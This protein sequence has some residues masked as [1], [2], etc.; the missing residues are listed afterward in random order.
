MTLVV[1][2]QRR[3]RRGTPGVTG[4]RSAS[5]SAIASVRRDGSAAG[6]GG[7][8]R[9]LGRGRRVGR[10]AGSGVGGCEGRLGG[11]DGIGIRG[12]RG[13]RNGLS[14]LSH[15]RSA[16]A[17]G[18]AAASGVGETSSLV[19]SWTSEDALR[20][21]RR[22]FPIDAPTSGSLPGPRMSSA[23]T[24][25]MIELGSPDVRHVSWCSSGGMSLS[26]SASRT[27]SGRRK[28]PT[29]V[30]QGGFATIRGRPGEAFPDIRRGPFGRRPRGTGDP[31]R[32]V[33]Q[34]APARVVRRPGARRR[35]RWPG[36]ARASPP[37]APTP[38][39]RN[40]QA[41]RDRTDRRELD[42][43]GGAH[44]QPDRAA[45]APAPARRAT[46]GYSGSAG[47]PASGAGATS[48]SCS[49]PA[50]GFDVRHST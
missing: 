32:D 10:G 31:P 13:R 8:A 24:R 25:M 18:A 4:S 33:H 11:R 38:G 42:R 29:R 6:G 44:D 20:N 45:R 9:R 28:P 39:T 50:P 30:A 15:G 19:A 49:S 43:G 47:A 35:T 14:G 37:C 5:A 34:Q 46:R 7:L 23:I 17:T 16:G 48:R 36:P 40:A 3:G 1:V 22:L 27:R 2:G 12:G 41:R 21:S 26:H